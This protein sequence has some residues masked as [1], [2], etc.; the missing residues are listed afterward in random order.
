MGWNGDP[1]LLKWAIIKP[2]PLVAKQKHSCIFLIKQNIPSLCSRTF[3]RSCKTAAQRTHCKSGCKN[4]I[5]ISS[6]GKAT[7]GCLTISCIACLRPLEG[8]EANVL[9][10][11]VTFFLNVL[12]P[13]GLATGLRPCLQ[14]VWQKSK[15]NQASQASAPETTLWCC[16]GQF[17]IAVQSLENR[18]Y[19]TSYLFTYCS[20][21]YL[22]W[23]YRQIVIKKSFGSR[24]FQNREFLYHGFFCVGK[25]DCFS[26][27]SIVQLIKHFKT[28]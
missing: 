14:K 21:L 8:H 7:I 9:F 24:N 4:N 2:L 26:A 25:W 20:F 11:I 1:F 27:R 10:C 22:F 12:V 17:R 6:C 16:A 28:F 15:E 18:F 3:L 19:C 5:S 23:L 13:C